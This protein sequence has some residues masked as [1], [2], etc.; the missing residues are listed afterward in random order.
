MTLLDWSA[1][2]ATTMSEARSAE[3]NGAGEMTFIR[4]GQALRFFLSASSN[5]SGLLPLV[6][7]PRA[8]RVCYSS[9]MTQAEAAEHWERRARSELKIA[10]ILFENAEP[11]VYGAILFHCHLSLELALKAEYIR[12]YDSAAPF[13]HDINELAAA[14]KEGWQKQEKLAFEQLT[15][16]AVLARYGDEE[17]L[18][19]NATR[20]K[21]EEWLKKTEVFISIL[22]QS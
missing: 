11:D 1:A 8:G 12:Q 15:E 10:R 21:A 6:P 14:V 4:S 2:G 18:K 16:F 7:K 3:S 13:T 20:D 9:D 5:L 22:L 19:E 17:W